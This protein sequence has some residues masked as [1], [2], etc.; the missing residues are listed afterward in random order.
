MPDKIKYYTTVPR[1]MNKHI[2]TGSLAVIMALGSIGM[3]V[4]ASAQYLGNVGDAGETGKL[5]LEE[6]LALQQARIDAVLANPGAGSGTPYLSA[7][8]VVGATALSA[9]IFGGIAATFFLRARS[10]KYAA[11]GRG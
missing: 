4:D 10:G 5:T 6:A 3:V 8:S 7:D 9:A 11:M 2:L 1:S